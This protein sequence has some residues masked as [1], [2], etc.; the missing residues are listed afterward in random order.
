[1]LPPLLLHDMERG[2]RLVMN[3]AVEVETTMYGVRGILGLIR[4]LTVPTRE[5]CLEGAYS[6]RLL[7]TATLRPPSPH[8]SSCNL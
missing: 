4:R 8:P 1:M 2:D 5:S 7:S 3:H 6:P